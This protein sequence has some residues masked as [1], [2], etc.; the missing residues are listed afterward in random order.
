MEIAGAIAVIVIPILLRWLSLYLD[1]DKTYENLQIG[2]LDIESG[3]VDAV[4]ERLDRVLAGIKAGDSVTGK[5]N[6]KDIAARL[7]AL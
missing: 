1:R 4:N 2:R 7:R 6:D 5:P 3:N